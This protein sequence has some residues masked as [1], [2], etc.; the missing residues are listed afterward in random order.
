MT[1]FTSYL[2]FAIA[3]AFKTVLAMANDYS[4]QATSDFNAESCTKLYGMG[5]GCE[6]V[7]IRK[8]RLV[9][10]VKRMLE[11]VLGRIQI[12]TYCDVLDMLTASGEIAIHMIESVHVYH[13]PVSEIKQRIEH[14]QT[15]NTYLD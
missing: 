6:I 3:N 7:G 12:Q 15:E 13:L 1:K 9:W 4:W 8:T 2:Q 11:P 10:H 5:T 14:T